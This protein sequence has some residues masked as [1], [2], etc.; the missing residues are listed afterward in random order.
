MRNGCDHLSFRGSIRLEH[1]LPA[2]MH[3]QA[4]FDAADSVVQV[5]EHELKTAQAALGYG[6][7][8]FVLRPAPDVPGVLYR[9]V[10]I[11]LASWK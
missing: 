8:G 9:G 7:I 10:E 11:S 5:A 2:A 4:E 6:S 1:L 3:P